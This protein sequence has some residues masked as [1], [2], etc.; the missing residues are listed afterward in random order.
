MTATW[1][2]ETIEIQQTL[3]QRWSEIRAP[4]RA[5]LVAFGALVV[6]S[7][8]R[9]GTGS[10]DLTSSGTAAA[11][12]RL[13]VPIFFAGL[14]GL[15]SERAG[16]VN[17][18]LEGMM[19]LGTW[20]SA[21]AGFTWG[22]WWG[23]L[24]ALIGGAIG[25]L[26]HAVATITFGVDHVVS[27]VAINIIALGLAR[28]LASEV[29][30]TRGGSEA[31][32]PQVKGDVGEF[33][34]PF[35]SGGKLFGW[36]S[37]DILGWFDDRNWVVVSDFA[38]LAS[39]L[40]TGLSNLTL[41]AI[42]L[43]PTTTY[44]LYRTRF[45]LRLRASGENPNA[46]DSQGV[47]VYGI[48]YAAVSISGALAGLGG[49]FLVIEGARIYREG[50]TAGR[51]FIALAAL[52]FGNWHAA[53]VAAGSTLFGFA[54]ALELRQEGTVHS[55]LLFVAIVV[56]VLAV[57]AFLQMNPRSVLL[58]SATSIGF[59][60]AWLFTDSVAS[61]FLSFTPHLTVL[62]VLTFASQR[63]RPPMAIGM[64]WRKGDA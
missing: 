55:L 32:S 53:G 60:L 40:T 28:Y 13:A 3:F 50:Q 27:G 44:V 9:W 18:G 63:L 43:I 64:L 24:A 54:N 62:I 48:R 14:G 47:S 41:I 42:A 10:E 49:A 35:L 23:V 30:T 8:V 16:I 22:V 21:W 12:L 52:I 38:G 51:G 39:G 29:F 5:M 6:L 58:L 20:S 26:F 17:I 36:S 7:L 2:T 31:N 56:A 57:R 34:V 4:Y 33:T 25:G 59:F 46:P 37:P 19:I 61:Q 45:G 11:T 15:Y 1:E